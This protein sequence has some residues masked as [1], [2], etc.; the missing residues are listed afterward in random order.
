[1]RVR[2]YPRRR[3]SCRSPTMLR[4]YRASHR[5]ISPSRR[6]DVSSRMR[7]DEPLAHQS[8]VFPRI[9]SCSSVANTNRALSLTSTKVG[10]ACPSIPAEAFSKRPIANQL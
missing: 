7:D 1:M 5:C 2:A 4:K 3:G 10:A 6:A 8:L 9:A